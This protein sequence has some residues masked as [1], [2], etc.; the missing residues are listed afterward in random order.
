MA[1][2]REGPFWGGKHPDRYGPGSRLFAR[3]QPNLSAERF[4]R[5]DKKT[6][7]HSPRRLIIIK[8]SLLNRDD[9]LHVQRQVRNAVKWVLAGFDLAER[10]RD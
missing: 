8:T 3:Q 7:E 1:R 6:A 2:A 9:T 5:D 4:L 10:D